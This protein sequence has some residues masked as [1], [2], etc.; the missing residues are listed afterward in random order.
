[1]KPGKALGAYVKS[2]MRSFVVLIL[3]MVFTGFAVGLLWKSATP[4]T[5][6]GGLN[7]MVIQNTEPMRQS[8]TG[9]GVF[10]KASL[11][12]RRTCR[13]PEEL[14][15]Q[16]FAARVVRDRDLDLVPIADFLHD[17]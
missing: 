6:S 5:T 10:C 13:R 7:T 14:N 9:L 3:V 1:M 4:R 2:R 16:A 11:G 15:G 17:R 12:V 8:A